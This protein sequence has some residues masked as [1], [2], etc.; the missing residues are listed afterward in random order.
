MALDLFGEVLKRALS[1]GQPAVYAQGDAQS[2]PLPEGIFDWVICNAVF[3]HFT[4]KTR[5]LAELRRVL[6][7]PEPAE[8]RAGGR[9]VVCHTASSQ[10]INEFHRSVGVVVAHDTPDEGEVLRLLREAG[11]DRV[12]LRD[13]PDRLHSAPCRL[14]C[15]LHLDGGADLFGERFPFDAHDLKVGLVDGQEQFAPLQRLWRWLV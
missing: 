13:K 1:K 5:A 4:D 3:P 2:L 6:R 15:V 10:A 9:L 14:D 7:S 12:I 8:G 11:L